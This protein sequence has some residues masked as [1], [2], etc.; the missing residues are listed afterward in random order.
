MT[1]HPPTPILRSFS[2]AMA[3]EFYEGFLGLAVDWRHRFHEDAPL[4]M[5]MSRGRLVLHLS[6]HFGDASPGATI[7]VPT[8]DL[9]A[10]NA[11]LLGKCYRNARPGIKDMP[12][13]L[14]EMRVSDPFGNRVVFSRHG[15]TPEV[16]DVNSRV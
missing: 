2:E 5:Q 14:R 1:L 15:R 6:E 7:R 8:D 10:L 13:G 3:L 16:L 12:W 11:E 9:D 4:Y